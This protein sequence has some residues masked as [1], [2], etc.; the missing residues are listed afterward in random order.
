MSNAIVLLGA[1]VL[2]LSD[3]WEALSPFERF[4]LEQL[5][6]ASLAS[7]GLEWPPFV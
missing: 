4:L 7:V 3:L 5:R 2:D 6:D 1:F